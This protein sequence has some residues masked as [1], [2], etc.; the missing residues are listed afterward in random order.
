[1]DKAPN[2]GSKKA[3]HSHKLRMVGYLFPDWL[4]YN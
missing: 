1:M 3:G 4:A 2:L